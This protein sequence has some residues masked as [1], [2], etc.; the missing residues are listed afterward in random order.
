MDEQFTLTEHARFQAGIQLNLTPLGA[1]RLFAMPM[2]TLL[3][4]VVELD[5]VLPGY[6]RGFAEHL[7]TLPDWSQRLDDGDAPL[8]RHR[9]GLR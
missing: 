4:Q 3:R 7:A 9:V 2:R 6:Q 1:A 8:E 5:D